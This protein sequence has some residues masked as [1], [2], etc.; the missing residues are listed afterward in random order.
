M[1]GTILGTPSE[2]LT[3]PPYPPSHPIPGPRNL[4]IHE[5]LPLSS[6]D[7]NARVGR[8]PIPWPLGIGTHLCTH[9]SLS[10]FSPP[11]SF[12]SL[13]S[14]SR[15]SSG[16]LTRHLRSRCHFLNSSPFDLSYQEP[17]TL[18]LSPP[19]PCD[20]CSGASGLAG[21]PPASAVG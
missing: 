19:W 3:K 10:P 11:D 13:S 6:A 9:C 1:L 2:C 18:S 20:T 8:L 7:N 14:I 4:R 15:G 16:R 5:Q 21:D 12:F 17:S